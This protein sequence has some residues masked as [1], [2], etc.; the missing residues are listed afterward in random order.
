MC[1]LRGGVCPG[2]GAW[3]CGGF[4]SGGG[5][6]SR[7]VPGLGGVCSGGHLVWGVVPGPGGVSAPGGWGGCPVETPQDSY[8]CGRYA[9]YWNAFLFDLPIHAVAVCYLNA[10][11]NF[12][13]LCGI[14]T[15][16]LS[17]KNQIKSKSGCCFRKREDNCLM[18]NE[19]DYQSFCKVFGD[20]HHSIFLSKGEKLFCDAADI[21]LLDVG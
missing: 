21:P 7:G 5:A 20:S 3:S 18:T 4:C 13:K 15:I 14:S 6:W 9:S 11:I 19:K 8:C 12:L 1:L 17:F 16:Q 10:K 2:G